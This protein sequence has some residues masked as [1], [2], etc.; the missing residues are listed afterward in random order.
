MLSV[1]LTGYNQSLLFKR[2]LHWLAKQDFDRPWELVVIDDFSSE[3]WSTLLEPYEFDLRYIRLEHDLGWRCCE[4]GFNLAYQQAKYDLLVSMNPH[5]IL[6]PS[7]FTVLHDAYE[8]L[9]RK[10]GDK[11]WLSLRGYCITRDDMPF[12]D[13]VDWAND[14]EALKQ[15]PKF[16]NPFTL[17]W[18]SDQF[19]G[20]FLCCIF[21]KS[22]WFRDIAV[23][24][25]RGIVN[26]GPPGFPETMA[27]GALDPWFFG[28]RRRAGWADYNIDIRRVWFYHQDHFRVQE[29]GR[30]YNIRCLLNEH[31]QSQITAAWFGQKWKPLSPN[32]L[33]PSP[34][35]PWESYDPRKGDLPELRSEF[36]YMYEKSWAREHAPWLVNL[37]RR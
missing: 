14:F 4:V 34:P 17:L 22:A 30:D 32:G 3:D 29:L 20:S 26:A 37:F 2:S 11:L 1:V 6:H 36:R 9:A 35:L 25:H 28:A 31:G 21:S 27:Y 10:H 16:V 33:W 19:Y 18:E 5:L 15:L 24:E 12:F 8:Y 13:T 7:A 23:K